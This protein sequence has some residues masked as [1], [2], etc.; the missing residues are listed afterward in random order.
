M[1]RDA[2]DFDEATAQA[3]DAT[4]RTPDVVNQ[5]VKVLE[6]LNLKPGEQVLDIGAG[7]GLMAYEMGAIV[8]PSGGVTGIDQ[9]GAMLALARERCSSL[10]QTHFQV[11]DACAL[12][13]ENGTMDVAVSM[14]V[15]EYVPDTDAALAEIHRVLKPGGRVSILDTAWDSVAWHTHDPALTAR[16]L[17]TWERHCPHPNLPQLLGPKLRAAG[18]RP[19][20]TDLV[21]IFNPGYTAHSYS[22]AMSVMIGN[23]CAGKDGLSREDI[24]SWL[25]GLADIAA[26]GDWFFSLNRYVFSAVKI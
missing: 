10:P 17:K 25:A 15:H 12:P 26:R 24:D 18:F 22:A 5:R 11:A 19:M 2:V 13:V 8:G 14:Q 7:T 16:I 3:I 6:V 9:S 20:R 4:Y 21:P 23:Y 1:S